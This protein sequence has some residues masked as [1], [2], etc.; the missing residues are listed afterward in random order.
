MRTRRLIASV[1]AV[2]VAV[3][4]CLLPSSALAAGNADHSGHAGLA[5]HAAPSGIPPLTDERGRALTLHGWNLA[6]KDHRGA[7][8]LSGITERHLRDMAAHGFNFARLAVFWDDLEPR[9]G[10]FSERYLRK[11]E[12]IL[13][14]AAHYHVK[15]VLDAHQDVYGPKFGGHRGIPEWATRDDGLPYAPHP[16]DWFSEYYEPAVQAAFQHLYEDA[17]LR[18]AQARM[19][20]VLAKR[21]RDQPAL[22]GYDLINEPMGKQRP[23]EDLPGAARRVESTQITPMYGRLAAAIRAVDRRHWLFVEPT[24]VVGEGVPTS[25]GRVPD[26][27]VVYAPHFYNSAMELGKDYDPGAGWIEA[28]EA[29]VV[30]YPREQRVPVVVGEWGPPDSSLPQ[31]RR[32]YLDALASLARY[33]SGWAGWTWCY[34]GAYCALDAG[35]RFQRNKEL[36]AAPYAEVVAG[37]VRD[38]SYDPRARRYGL[39][40]EPRGGVS[41]LS[42]PGPGWRVSVT[43]PVRVEVRGRRVLL[44]SVGSRGPVTVTVEPGR[45]TAPVGRSGGAGS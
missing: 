10:Q 27:K 13:G 3:V 40:Y 9:R 18:A 14:W 24:P 45:E 35:G 6:D 8:A 42:L 33:S 15:V 20:G 25:L 22:L 39:R 4:S 44:R 41:E 21:F 23:G 43:G 26:P 29:A 7:S 30:R 36:M 19:W 37:L 34:G 32:Y 38:Q 1:P 2:G 16:G 5:G 11:I 12:R 31:M 17:D 28:Y